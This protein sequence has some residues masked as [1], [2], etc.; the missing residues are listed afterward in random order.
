[1]SPKR[2]VVTGM[3]VVCS[4]GFS[5]QELWDNMIAGKSGIR[6]VQ[7]LDL[8]GY[9]STS[10]GE[11]D[12]DRLA[13]AMKSASLTSWD[14]TVDMAQI[15]AG[16]ALRQARIRGE[17][18]PADPVD[19]GT[20][21][22][23]GVGCA[24]S[25]HAAYMGLAQKGL[26]GLRPTTVP[27][28]MA[29][30]ASAVISMQYRLTGPNF[31]IV[32]ACSSSTSAIGLAFRTI[33]SGYADMVLCGGADAMF[34]PGTFGSWNNLG[35]MSS[36]QDPTKACRPFDRDRDGTVLGE[37]AAAILLES[38]EHASARGAGIRAEICGYGESSD[39]DHITR[40]NVEGQMKAIRLALASAEME[41]ADVGFVNAHGTA[42]RANDACESQSIRG[43]LGSATDGIP[44][45][46][47]KSYFGHLLG[48]SGAIETL[49][50]VIG[51]ER[52]MMPSSLNLDNP[53][54]ECN[55]LFAGSTP[56]KLA[57]PVV[58]KNSFGFG[59][60]NAVLVLRAWR[61]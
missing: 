32:C 24:H 15:A 4:L 23:T 59:G 21:F 29:N 35:V 2:V 3:G 9:K 51:I 8:T 20:I 14:R 39:A 52:G 42:T 18:A 56:Q 38:L 34:E 5:E 26:R 28:C 13:V 60:D 44:V 33:Q 46:S 19:C 53:D 12:N 45:S 57:R 61:G 47:N 31:V 30:A 41:P 27:R 54:P 36:N 48:A 17:T 37:G 58:L 43:V 55:L 1:M 11:V 10:G 6:R 22:G 7:S 25:V 16:Q 49:V 50:S 40:P